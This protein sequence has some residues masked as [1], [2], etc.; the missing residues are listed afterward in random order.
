MSPLSAG[1]NSWTVVPW[2]SAANG[3]GKV[4]QLL[5]HLLFGVMCSTTDARA[6]S[7]LDVRHMYHVMPVCDACL[8]TNATYSLASRMLQSLF[9][10]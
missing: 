6:P 7:M 10:C 3:Q 5:N 4:Y 8:T 2:C 9:T 1:A